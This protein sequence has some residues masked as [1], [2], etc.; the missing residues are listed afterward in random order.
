MSEENSKYQVR[1]VLD[2]A[3]NLFELKN[4]DYGDSWKE[5]GWR[6]NL[7]RILE[8]AG[9]LRKV[10]RG[11]TYAVPDENVRETA[12]DMINTLAFLVINHDLGREWGHEATPTVGVAIDGAGQAVEVQYQAGTLRVRETGAGLAHQ[13]TYEHLKTEAEIQEAAHFLR[14]PYERIPDGSDEDSAFVKL[15]AQQTQE[16]LNPPATVPTKVSPS[17]R[18]RKAK[19]VDGDDTVVAEADNTDKS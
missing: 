3:L 7:S 11:G 2:E 5:Q 13:R 8:K 19:K 9:R 10:W 16:A 4:Q 12:L 18:P 17:P 15:N 6:G 1:A 14:I